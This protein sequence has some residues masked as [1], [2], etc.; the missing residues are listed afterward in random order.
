MGTNDCAKMIKLLLVGREGPLLNVL[1]RE[2]QKQFSIP[3]IIEEKPR[4]SQTKKLQ[5]MFRNT[6]LVGMFTVPIDVLLLAWYHISL[7]RRVLDLVGFRKTNFPKSNGQETLF[8]P[9]ITQFS[10]Q[11]LEKFGTFD[12][13]VVFGTSI[14]PANLIGKLPKP[15]INFHGGM[16]PHYRNVHGDFW[17]TAKRDKAHWGTSFLLLTEGVDDGPIV[18]QEENNLR[19]KRSVSR[20][21]AGNFLFGISKVNE[22]IE[23]YLQSGEGQDQP[24]SD[25]HD[26][27][28]GR[29]PTTWDWLRY[30]LRP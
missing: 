26:V 8:L 7:E 28:F 5:K 15:V 1:N 18:Y 9:H 29:T 19:F 13:T 10:E 30:G 23:E 22:A 27:F 14:I 4:S 25:L 21:A 11:C 17:A 24:N 12:G 2:L 16:V 3:L 20:N 6:S